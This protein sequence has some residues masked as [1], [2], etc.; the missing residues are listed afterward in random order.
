ME[1]EVRV[2]IRELGKG[3]FSGTSPLPESA[4]AANLCSSGDDFPDPF[5]HSQGHNGRVVS[6][7]VGRKQQ[8]PSV[9]AEMRAT[10]TDNRSGRELGSK[11]ERRGRKRI[12]WHRT[13]AYWA[14][15]LSSCAIA[16]LPT[17]LSNTHPLIGSNG[18]KH[19]LAHRV[20]T[21]TR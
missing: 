2:K 6:R 15:E 3:F 16:V 13:I 11:P 12:G 19:L 9:I 18:R 5:T 14:K 4:V 8:P 20:T 21:D 7:R 17:P 1:W 10:M